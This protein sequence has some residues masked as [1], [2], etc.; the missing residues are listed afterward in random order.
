MKLDFKTLTGSI[1]L[2]SSHSLMLGHKPSNLSNEQFC[3]KIAKERKDLLNL[4]LFDTAAPNYTTYYPDV[5][6]DD[7]NPKDGEF[8]FPVFRALSE[9][10]VSKYIP[11]DFGKKN[12]LKNS[13]SKLLGQTVNVDHETA[14]GNAIGAVKEVFWQNAYKTEAGKEVPAGINYVSMIDGK[15]NPRIARGIMMNPPS[16]HSNSVGIQFKWEPSHEFDEPSDFYNKVG[17]YDKD[18]ELVRALVTDIISYN[19]IS[20]VP[21]GADVF[22]Q[23]VGDDGKI[24]NPDYSHS[25]YNFSADD[26]MFDARVHI[27]YKEILENPNFKFNKTIPN[28]L[29]TSKDKNKNET[30]MKELT[31]EELDSLITAHQF[32]VGEL[33]AENVIEKLT[34]RL[35]QTQT[36]NTDLEAEIVTVKSS[37]DNLTAD[38]FATLKEEAAVGQKSLSASRLE[39]ERLYKLS[40]GETHDATIVNL[41]QSSDFKTSQ[42]LL[43]QYKL[44]CEEKFQSTC[45]SCGEAVTLGNAIGDQEDLIDEEGKPIE[46]KKEKTGMSDINST[47]DKFRARRKQSRITGGSK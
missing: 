20:L 32:E 41:I 22:A 34:E 28:K 40:K 47:I 29:N 38:E 4:G 19:E 17:T 43:E 30:K 10:I 25:V 21:H 42:S 7:L 16:I 36:S 12:V 23:K 8:I 18:G 24:I 35:T 14:I 46:T 2:G 3:D 5:T 26:G 44:E 45:E 6:A 31:Q 11:I 15:S 27:D 1:Q 39:A 13:M 37:Y 9:T 33:T